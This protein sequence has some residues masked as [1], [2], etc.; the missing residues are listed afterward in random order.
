MPP[1]QFSLERAA[2]AEFSRH[3]PLYLAQLVAPMDDM[4]R[5]LAAQ[6][7]PIALFVDGDLAGSCAL[8]AEGQLLQFFVLAR[9]HHLS[10]PLL[11]FAF[12]RLGAEEMMVPTL[13]PNYLCTSMDI[14]AR[15]EVHSMLYA[16]NH[17]S[18]ALGPVSLRLAAAQDHGRCV[19][20][21]EREL[22]VER[23]F[24]EGYVGARI[25]RS[26]LFLLEENARIQAVGELRRDPLQAGISQLGIIVQGD[27]RGQ[28]IG[29]RVLYSLAHRS[30]GEGLIPVCSTEVHNQAARRA[31]ERAGFHSNHRLLRVTA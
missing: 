21:E 29:S 3:T 14:A 15:V 28:G 4:W 8:N 5:S 23:A 2:Q 17:G 11:R 12:D 30:R 19:D 20:F 24:L 10:E 7:D 9:F 18:E 27:R 25:E 1:P 22:G 31:I 16:P 13:D 26:E 6:A